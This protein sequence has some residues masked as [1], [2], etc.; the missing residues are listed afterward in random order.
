MESFSMN[1]KKAPLLS[2]WGAFL[3]ALVKR[4]SNSLK[5]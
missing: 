5:N 2:G 3:K 1:N 4:E